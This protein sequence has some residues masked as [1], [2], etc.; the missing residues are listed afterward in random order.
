MTSLKTAV[1]GD[2]GVVR[3]SGP[4]A[5]QLLQGLI[6]NDIERTKNGGAIYAALLTP[7]GKVLFDFFI[8]ERDGAY[9]F[10]IDGGAS[11]NFVR[12][13]T[14]YKLRADVQIVD[15]SE[16]F[17]VRAFF[18]DQNGAELAGDGF[19]DPRLEAMGWRLISPRADG[20]DASPLP[21]AQAAPAE[22]Y[23]T[24]RI[25]QGIPAFGSEILSE[26]TFPLD[27]NL[28][29]LNAI[30]FQ[31]GCYVGQEV[32]SRTKRRGSI[33]KR[34]L[35]FQVAGETPAPE[36]P[37]M[38]GDSEIGTTY[39]AASGVGLALIRLDRWENARSENRQP[40]INGAAAEITIPSYLGELT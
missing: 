25:A 22:D 9:L 27:F 6:T 35:Q 40:E 15:V 16:A 12:R 38:A 8:V 19:I 13:L 21:E 7:Q 23:E 17:E 28:D 31:K 2:R 1:L 14:M 26:K 24:W 32:T 29:L 33:R 39:S 10:D 20:P 11:A 30:D 3:V 34:L 37:V 4:D 5:S 18:G 36:T